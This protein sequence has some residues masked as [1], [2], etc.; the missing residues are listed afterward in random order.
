[1]F[2]NLIQLMS[3]KRLLLQ[4]RALGCPKEEHYEHVVSLVLS[5]LDTNGNLLLGCT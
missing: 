4:E 2:P 1:M 3:K 5:F